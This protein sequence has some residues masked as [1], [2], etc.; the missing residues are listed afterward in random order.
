[1]YVGLSVT[2]ARRSAGWY[3][4]LLG[5]EVVR[6]NFDSNNWPSDWNEVLLREPQSGL[7]LGLI[8]HQANDGKPFNE[9][10]TG[11]DHIELEVSSLGELD[12]WEAKL[13]ELGIE[14]SRAQ[15]HLLTFRDPDNIQLEFFFP[16]G[17]DL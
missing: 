13:R 4:A 15:A 11:L 8:E 5:T 2:D 10:R 16:G 6:E 12:E 3:H 17:E 1:M 7:L 9:F 14:S